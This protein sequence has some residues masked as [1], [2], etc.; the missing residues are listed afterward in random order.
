MNTDYIGGE[1]TLFKEAVH[2]KNYLFSQFARF[3]KGDLLEVGAGIGTN[4][5]MMSKR[6]DIHFNSWTATEIDKNQ[7]E[8]LKNVKDE[9]LDNRYTV[10]DSFVSDLEQ[11]YDTILYID[12]IEH[13]ENDRAELLNAKSKLNPQGHLVILCPAHNWLFSPFDKSI[14]HF[15]RYNKK[16][17]LDILPDGFEVVRLRYLD[18]V[19][20]LASATN[21][22]F[23]QQSY[24]TPANIKFWDEYIIPFSKVFDQIS[25]YILGKSVLIVAKKK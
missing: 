12:V 18:S 6:N 25:G 2:W 22:L 11:T 16:M 1:L 4:M 7:V 5:V 15:R 20:I 8:I 3:I 14:G 19:G 23:L 13:I 24:P 9:Q 10:V 21:K 17:Y